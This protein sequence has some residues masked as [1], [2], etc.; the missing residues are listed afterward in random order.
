[1]WYTT[2]TELRVQT[3]DPWCKIHPWLYLGL[4]RH[5]F[6]QVTWLDTGQSYSFLDEYNGSN[7]TLL[8]QSDLYDHSS[9]GRKP[10]GLL[11]IADQGSYVIRHPTWMKF[12]SLSSSGMWSIVHVYKQKLSYS[13]RTEVPLI[14]LMLINGVIIFMTT[15]GIL[16]SH[17]LNEAQR[18]HHPVWPLTPSIESVQCNG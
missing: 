18:V 7:S 15:V 13:N 9:V 10:N 14:S 11:D 2:P 6:N 1:M 3:W 4:T 17:D 12:L 8:D 16:H 5:H